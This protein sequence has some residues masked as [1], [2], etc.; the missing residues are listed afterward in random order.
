MKKFRLLSSLALLSGVAL[1]MTA[2]GGK[3]DNANVSTKAFKSAVPKKEVKKGGTLRQALTTNTPFTGVFL[4][5]LADTQDDSDVM[6]PANESLFYVDDSYGYNDEGPATIKM[7]VKKKTV[8]VKIKKGVKWSDGKQ[9]CA[10]DYEY[11]Y[12]IIANKDTQT[13][14]Y[15]ESLQALKGLTEYHDGKAKT[16]SGIEMPDGEKGLTVVLHY[17]EMKPGMRQSGNGFIWECAVPYHYLKDVPFKKL[18][19]SDKVRKNPLFFGPYKFSKIVRGQSAT[20]VRNPYYWRGKPN[21][22]KV[23]IQVLNPNNSSQALKSHKFDIIG[24]RN[25]QWKEVKN[26][27]GVNF[28]GKVGLGYSYVGFKVGKWSAKKGKNIMNPKAKMNNKALR[29]A[30]AYGMNIAPVYKRYTNGLTFQIPTLIPKQF[31]AFY[32]GSVKPYTQDFKKANKLLDDAGY[33]KKGKWRVQPNGK[34]LVIHFA[35][36]SGSAIQ[37]P[38]IQNYL[39]QWHKLGLNVKLAGGRLIEMNSFYDK[40]MHDDPSV[41]MFMA[42][43]GLS[44][45]PSPNDLYN[46]KAP[47][48][49]TRFVTKKN[50]ELLKAIDSTKAFNKKYRIAKFHEWQKYMADEL[51]VLPVANNWSIAAVNSKISGYDASPSASCKFWMNCGFIK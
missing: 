37:E 46:E 7:D 31:G 30:I 27:K 42:A 33:K 5:E 23:V 45:E 50:S 15:T 32:N 24:V 10:K 40:V 29:Q 9:V 18:K 3:S 22:D 6:S 41:D 49:F 19:E 39:K 51:Y 4:N 28:V 44:S 48:N 16:I 14:R 34:P 12:E 47:Y 17:K 11:A 8:T 1:T 43:W 35:A 36:M 21:F 13:S 2:C 20:F 26:T 25:S 38:I